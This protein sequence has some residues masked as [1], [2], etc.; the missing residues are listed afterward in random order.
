MYNRAAVRGSV[1]LTQLV[2]AVP[3]AACGYY[4]STGYFVAWVVQ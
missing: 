2:L 4:Q 1:S 3:V